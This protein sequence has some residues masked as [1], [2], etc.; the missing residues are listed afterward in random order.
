MGSRKS[1]RTL[2]D[3]RV[4]LSEWWMTTRSGKPYKEA[5]IE[6]LQGMLKLLA[7]DHRRREKV[8]AKEKAQREEELVK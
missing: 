4:S 7:E 3:A 2:S 8:I 1:R 5:T 6:E